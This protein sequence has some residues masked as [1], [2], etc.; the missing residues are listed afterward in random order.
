MS[1]APYSGS[2]SKMG[3][4]QWRQV[5]PERLRKRQEG[6]DEVEKEGARRD[7]EEN[8]RQAEHE[9]IDEVAEWQALTGGL[10]S[11]SHASYCI[12]CNYYELML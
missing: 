7:E 2:M 5:R 3:T 8:G 1:R 11:I 12:F 6:A 9:A 4:T 10:P